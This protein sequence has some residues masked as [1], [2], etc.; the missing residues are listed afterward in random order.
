VQEDLEDEVVMNPGAKAAG[1]SLLVDRYDLKAIP[2]WHSSMISPTGGTRITRQDGRE[3][4]IFPQVYWP[5]EDSGDHLEFAL[6]FEGINLGILAALFEKMPEPDLTDWISPRSTGKY[7]RRI[8]FLYEFLTGK[9]L[10]IPD[11]SR[12]NYVDVLDSDLYYVDRNARR[13]TR[14]RVMDNLLG[15]PTFCPIVRRTAKLQNMESMDIRSRCEDLV[16]AYPPEILHRAMSYLYTKETKSSFQIENV[17]PSA[18]RTEKYISLLTTAER[19]DFCDKTSLLEIQNQIVDPRY[20]ESDYRTEPNYVGQSMTYQ[21]QIVHYVSPRPEDLPPLM[22]GLLS[23]HRRL[24]TSGIP[25]II[26][27]AVISYGFV[28][29]HPFAD[30]NGRIHRFLIHNILF[31]R[32]LVPESIMF[33]VSAAMLRHP[34]L[35]DRSLEAF[36][37]PLME[38]I[39]YT[40]HEFGQLTIHGSTAGFYRSI[41]MTEQAEALF[42]FVRMTLEEEL[43]EELGFLF[44][45]DRTKRAI[46]AIVDMPDARIDLFVH[47]CL[48]NQGRLSSKKRAD[49]FAMLNDEELN[50]MEEAVKEG[51][52][53]K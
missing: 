36:S 1:Y 9:R 50:R 5:G 4:T 52:L 45:Y 46:Q 7:V 37:K 26:H 17:S 8:W 33:P 41:D 25:A 51:Y 3:E 21:K 6:K 48:Q 18:T 30:G 19:R 16:A 13:V 31:L 28:F 24:M 35:Y 15:T 14:Q 27:A 10:S 40:L 12:I 20:K 49:F 32:G 38:R 47:L 2:N 29:L 11:L 44:S 43:V 39:E 22:D 53:T 23:C 34:S 42:D